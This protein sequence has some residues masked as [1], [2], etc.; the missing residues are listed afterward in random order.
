MIHFGFNT[1]KLGWGRV[2]G[3]SKQK[4]SAIDRNIAVE[5]L[6]SNRPGAR[7][8]SLGGAEI[9]FGEHE[10]FIHVN[11]RRARGHEKFI[12]VWIKRKR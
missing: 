4:F 9:N 3:K 1:Q 11:S 10:K 12:R 5:L 8:T 2:T 6:Q 7:I